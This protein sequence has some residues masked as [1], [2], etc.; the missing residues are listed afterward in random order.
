MKRTS[1]KDMTVEQLV[2]HFAAIAIDQDQAM[3]VEANARYNRLYGEMDIVK[4]EL[5]HRPGDQRRALVPL[6]KHPNAQ[7]RLKAAIA[8]LALAPEAARKVLQTIHDRNEYPQAPYAYGMLMAL[9][10]GSYKPS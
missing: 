4:E 3:R 5:K 10:D 7:V 1:T 6:L 8:T 2:D 9:D